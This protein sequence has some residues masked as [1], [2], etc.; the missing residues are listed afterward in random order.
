MDYFSEV[1]LIILAQI[2]VAAVHFFA[3]EIVYAM[4]APRCWEKIERMCKCKQSG[5]SQFTSESQILHE[6]N[7]DVTP[8]KGR[9]HIPSKDLDAQMSGKIVDPFD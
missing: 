6:E 2:I 3:T 8:R 1:Q 7:I 5:P 9:S 4:R